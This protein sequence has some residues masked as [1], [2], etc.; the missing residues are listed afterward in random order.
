MPGTSFPSAPSLLKQDVLC[1]PGYHA[2]RSK[3]THKPLPSLKRASAGGAPWCLTLVLRPQAKYRHDTGEWLS[4]A[5]K[6]CPTAVSR[7]DVP[8]PEHNG[9]PVI[10]SSLDFPGRAHARSV[11]P[12]VENATRTKLGL[13]ADVL[14]LRLESGSNTRWHST[15]LARARTDKGMDL[16]V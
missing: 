11:G 9:H 4:R 12:I 15:V 16:L 13:R 7:S 6:Q 3:H 2:R 5:F 8:S 14:T 1:H 10:A